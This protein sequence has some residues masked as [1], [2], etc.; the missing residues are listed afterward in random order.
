MKNWKVLFSEYLIKRPWL[1]VRR[2]KV[3]LP[4][5]K[6]IPEYYVLEYPDWVNIIA[7]TKDNQIVIERQFRHGVDST[8]YEIPSGVM[9]KGDVVIR[10]IWMTAKI[11]FVHDENAY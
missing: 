5:G 9:E 11:I 10:I 6:I 3:L 4:N 8:N 2:D 1:T 7:V